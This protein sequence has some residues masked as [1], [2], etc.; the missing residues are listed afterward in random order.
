VWSG[1]RDCRFLQ[2]G[3]PAFKFHFPSEGRICQKNGRKDKVWWVT[4]RP[5]QPIL[6]VGPKIPLKPRFEKRACKV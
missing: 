6:I 4:F 1:N 5:I 3:D 2:R